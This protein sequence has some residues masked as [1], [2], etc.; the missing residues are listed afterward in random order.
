MIGNA[1]PFGKFIQ[2]RQSSLKE[3]TDGNVLAATAKQVSK[4]TIQLVFFARSFFPVAHLCIMQFVLTFDKN[5][6]HSIR[7]DKLDQVK[8]DAASEIMVG[9]KE[10]SNDVRKAADQLVKATK[11]P[12]L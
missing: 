8:A 6:Y 5:D 10:A 12:S 2:N 9:L 4:S 3:G 11:K 7:A 1:P